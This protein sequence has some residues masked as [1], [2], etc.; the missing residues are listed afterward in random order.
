MRLEIWEGVGTVQT[1]PL[2]FSGRTLHVNADSR[3]EL[4]RVELPGQ[5][6]LTI[7]GFSADDCV[8]LRG[9]SVDTTIRWK[10]TAS[11]KTAAR[12]PRAAEVPLEQDATVLVLDRLTCRMPNL[13]KGSTV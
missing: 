5:D 2:L 9:D 11:L 6:G 12:R 13:T 7:P 10:Q 3:H 8:P 4:L 1:K